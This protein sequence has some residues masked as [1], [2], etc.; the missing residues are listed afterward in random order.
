VSLDLGVVLGDRYRLTSRIAAGGMGEV[1]RAE[2]T[3]LGRIV[4]VKVMRPGLSGDPGFL[5]RFRAEA[6]NTA[7]LSHPGIA[8]VHDYG[9][10]LDPAGGTR[11]FLVM[12]L[13][14]GEPLSTVLDRG[15]LEPSRAMDMLAQTARALH[16]AHQSGVV[17]RDVKPGNL[18]VRTDG[19]VV[20]TDFGI[21]RAMGAAGM[22]ATGQV[23]GTAAYISPEQAAGQPATPASDVYSLGVVGYQ[24]LSGHKPFEGEN[25]LTV[26]LAHMRQEPP[27]LTEDLPV[28]ARAVVERSLAK[29]PTLRFASASE[30]AEASRA[31][32]AAPYDSRLAAAT[33]Q[34]LGAGAAGASTQMFDDDPATRFLGHGGTPTSPAQPTSPPRRYSDDY[35]GLGPG[36]DRRYDDTSYGRYDDYDGGPRH[37]RQ[38]GRQ[39]KGRK[40][41]VAVIVGL[42]ALLALGLGIAA[43]MS[44]FG[45]DDTPKADNSPTQGA[46]T[47]SPTSAA[48]ETVNIDEDDY[49]GKTFREAK[50]ELVAKGFKV[51]NGGEVDPENQGDEEG[52]VADVSPSGDVEKGETITLKVFGPQPNNDDGDGDDGGNNQT[53]SPSPEPSE[54]SESPPTS[55]PGSGSPAPEGDGA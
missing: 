9:E 2:D 8:T 40:V 7:S 25:P 15:R 4:A 47:P 21:A 16:A 28:A 3:V 22:T 5:H 44:L 54:P 38:D 53:E 52:T 20:V 12:E 30:M 39:G 23:L 6:R 45:G 46:P 29:E 55:K 43:A 27:P 42:V 34:M 1:W 50:V 32:A 10:T 51:K 13:V 14:D 35:P 11:A 19:S 48:A 33:T 41:G 17:H 37:G 24:M 26:A 31:A 36:G 49:L 18:L